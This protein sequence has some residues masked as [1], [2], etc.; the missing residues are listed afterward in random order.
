MCPH[1]ARRITSPG[2]EIMEEYSIDVEALDVF[3]KAVKIDDMEPSVESLRRITEL[4]LGHVP[5]TNIMMLNRPRRSPRFDEITD[6]MLSLR[7]GPCGHF[8]PFMNLL[9]KRIGFDSSLVPAKMNGKLSHM[10]IVTH[11]EG[12]LWWNDFGN[13]HPYLSPIR[14]ESSEEVTHAGLTYAITCNQD[15]SFAVRHRYLGDN[16]FTVDYSFENNP[17]E[18]SY[19]KEMIEEHYTNEKF[20]PFLTGLRFIR[21][22]E[23]EMVA[24]RDRELLLTKDGLL[25][26]HQFSDS[27]EIIDAVKKHFAQAD[28]PIE[29]GLRSLGW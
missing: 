22:P 15:G 19:F 16:D 10:A 1:K 6:D 2:G 28:Y 8:N 18:F 20:G 3:Q 27:S 17:V 14:L 21:F 5:F 26:K 4:V 25:E 24:I 13:G 12:D 7:G 11:I 23:G 29:S 9:L